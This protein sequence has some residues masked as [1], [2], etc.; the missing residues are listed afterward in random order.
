LNI[1]KYKNSFTKRT[2]QVALSLCID[3]R[4]IPTYFATLNKQP[5]E[6]GLPWLS[7]GAIRFLEKFLR[8]NM[9][10]F[11]YGSGGSTVFFAS[12]CQSIVSVE[13]NAEWAKRVRDRLNGVKNA[14]VIFSPTTKIS[15]GSDGLPFDDVEFS[16][17]DYVRA[18]DGM[19]P[20][21]VMIDGSE[22]WLLKQTR[23]SIC[24]HHI[25]PAMKRGTIIILDDSWAYPELRAENRAKRVI[26]FWGVGPCRKGCTSTDVFFY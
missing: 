8:P 22:D 26:T 5:L 11:E 21:V 16:A 25:E 3:P 12:R 1:D 9:Q 18:I 10:I 14:N 20:E 23:R 4:S 2:A 17:S 19:A 13:D 7:F 15:H 6:L 24:F